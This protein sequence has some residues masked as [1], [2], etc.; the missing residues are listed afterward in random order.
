MQLQ[1]GDLLLVCTD[2]VEEAFN[3]SR[4]QLG[5]DAVNR[6]LESSDRQNLES[7]G[8]AIMTAVD[9][10]QGDEPQS[11]DITLLLLQPR[12]AGSRRTRITLQNDFGAVSTLQTWLEQLLGE[13][14]VAE[15]IQ[16]ELKLVSEEVVTNIFKYGELAAS[17]GV[18]I[19]LD[20]DDTRVSLEFI[21][22]GIPFN[23]LAEAER[24][25]LGSDIESAAIGGLGVHLLEGLTDEQSYRR[26]A[27]E[28]RLELVK[29][30]D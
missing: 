20:I 16:A 4:E 5:P 9:Q 30:L 6:M 2:G 26:V 21:D 18:R 10:H 8:R 7:V 11:D 17:D 22:V 19:T 14:E 23:P 12:A 24:S 3:A 13:A 29:Y 28:N 25:D 27:G 1:P 15:D